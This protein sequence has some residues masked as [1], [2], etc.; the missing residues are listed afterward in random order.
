MATKY[1]VTGDQYRLVDTRIQEIKRQLNQKSGSP[2]DPEWVAIRLQHIIE[3]KPEEQVSIESILFQERKYHQDFFG[4]EF[5]LTKFRGVLKKYELEAIKQWQAVGLELHFLPEITMFRENNF[6]GWKVRPIKEYWE[7]VAEGDI[8]R[9]DSKGNFVPD[10]DFFNLEGIV[11]LVV[12][13]RK[14]L[15]NS[16]IALIE[17]SN[18]ARG[19]ISCFE[20]SVVVWEKYGKSLFAEFLGIKSSQVRLERFI[21]SNV[22]SQLYPSMSK[23]T[24]REV[25]CEEYHYNELNRLFSMDPLIGQFV[26]VVSG[27]IYFPYLGEERIIRPL[28]VLSD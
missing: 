23:R 17:F 27:P 7:H 28:V 12:R 13:D 10:P 21:E 20:S 24:D 25:W 9:R 5:D 15:L 2:L 4:R 16:L 6:P 8:L 22:I 11:V 26:R 18:L 14:I 1:V 19:S 3:G